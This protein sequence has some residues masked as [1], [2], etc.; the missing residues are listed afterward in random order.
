MDGNL[1][2]IGILLFFLVVFVAALPEFDAIGERAIL[3]MVHS[4]TAKGTREFDREMACGMF[5]R[6][7]ISFFC[8]WTSKSQISVDQLLAPGSALSGLLDDL[9]R[10]HITPFPISA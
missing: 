5:R 7:F 1:G 10:R 9:E 2:H 4:F 3:S 8:L 6:M